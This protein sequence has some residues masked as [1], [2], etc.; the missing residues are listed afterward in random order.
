VHIPEII[1]NADLGEMVRDRE[2]YSSVLDSAFTT[3]INLAK[4]F[5]NVF[6]NY[7]NADLC[8]L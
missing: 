1:D 8:F 4:I 2:N 6:N 3:S 5:Q 7:K